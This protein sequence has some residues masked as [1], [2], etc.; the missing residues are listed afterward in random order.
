M[1]IRFAP[2]I[3]GA[4]I[5]LS[6]GLLSGYSVSNADF[7]WFASLV[8]PSFNPPDWIFGPVWTILYLMMGAALGKLWKQT[9]KEPLLISLF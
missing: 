7:T 8:K 6:L 3:I 4:L 1:R 9:P 2:E 5:C